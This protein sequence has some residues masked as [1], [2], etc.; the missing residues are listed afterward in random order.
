MNEMFRQ[1]CVWA[2]D[3]LGAPWMFISNVFLILLWLSSGPLFDFSDTWQLWVNTVTTVI[4]YLAIFLLQNTQN[5]DAKAIHLKLDEL[6]RSVEGARNQLV[7]LENLSDEE[8]TRLQ[9]QFQRLREQ[10]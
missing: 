1:F 10:T 8:L 7:D 3:A 9:R 6:I 4:T 5:R 2:A